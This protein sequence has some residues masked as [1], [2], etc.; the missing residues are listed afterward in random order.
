MAGGEYPYK[1]PTKHR[2]P[3]DQ[4]EN[5]KLAVFTNH[6]TYKDIFRNKLKRIKGQLFTIVQFYTSNRD[7]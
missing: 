2:I 6:I 1:G 4:V 3:L 5:H 7:Y